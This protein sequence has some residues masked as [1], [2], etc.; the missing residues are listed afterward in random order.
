FLLADNNAGELEASPVIGRQAC[1]QLGETDNTRAFEALAVRV[2]RMARQVKTDCSKLVLQ[3]FRG[4]PIGY[5]R[6][7]RPRHQVRVELAEEALLAAVALLGCEARL[8]QKQLSRGKGLCSV[9]IEAVEGAG[10]SKIFELPTVEALGIETTREIQEILEA[11]AG[12]TLRDEFAHR[13][14]ADPLDRGERIADGGFA[15][16]PSSPASGGGRG[17]G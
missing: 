2:K 4:R 11:A 13:L 16:T 10:F 1:R 5:Q 9:R 12:I 8:A 6:Q 7:R 15:P 3:L 17:G 14:L